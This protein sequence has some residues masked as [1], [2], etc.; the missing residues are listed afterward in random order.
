M[1]LSSAGQSS[2]QHS[3]GRRGINLLTTTTTQFGTSG[4]SSFLSPPNGWVPGMRLVGCYA[5]DLRKRLGNRWMCG[6]GKGKKGSRKRPQR[7]ETLFLC[8]CQRNFVLGKR[9]EERRE[10][11]LRSLNLPRPCQGFHPVL[12]YPCS[13]FVV[14]PKLARIRARGMDFNTS[15]LT[16]Q[17]KM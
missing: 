4:S 3:S 13:P 11:A 9:K 14:L 1:P 17:Q 12:G 8:A 5:L 10:T 7:D 2:P 15:M 16:R 6:K